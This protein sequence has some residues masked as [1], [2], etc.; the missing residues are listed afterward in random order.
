MYNNISYVK[1]QYAWIEPAC[2][3]QVMS[4]TH[5]ICVYL[6]QYCHNNTDMQW[7]GRYAHTT[8]FCQVLAEACEADI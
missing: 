2:K 7:G 6:S 8:T 4:Y 5:V 3:I 1:I